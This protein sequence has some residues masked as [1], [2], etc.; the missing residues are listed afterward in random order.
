MVS[1]LA[2]GGTLI[3]LE[4]PLYK[5]LSVGGPPFGL[6]AEVYEAALQH[7]GAEIVY[8]D[9]SKVVLDKSSGSHL[10]GLQKLA[11]WKPA[12][13]HEIGEGTDHVSMWK[14]KDSA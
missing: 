6:Q 12:K 3:C 11:R 14:K 7:P 8:D 2:P 1:L 13:T 10:D 4:F 5:E 9:K